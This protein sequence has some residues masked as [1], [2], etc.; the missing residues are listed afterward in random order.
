MAFGVASLFL[1]HSERGTHMFDRLTRK[2]IA[3]VVVVV[4]SHKMREWA[5]K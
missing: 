5:K 4:V 3:A 1:S 2:I